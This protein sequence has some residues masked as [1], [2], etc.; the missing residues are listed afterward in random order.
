V[1]L[2]E[3]AIMV[4]HLAGFEIPIGGVVM[5]YTIHDEI[6]VL[7]FVACLGDYVTLDEAL[8]L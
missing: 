3:D 8:G 1:L 7:S 4:D 6:H 5:D 2:E